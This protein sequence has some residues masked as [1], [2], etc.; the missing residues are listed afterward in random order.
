MIHSLL[1]GTRIAN[2]QRLSRAAIPGKGV[3]A[4]WI[5]PQLP[6]V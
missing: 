5:E 2:Q 4:F 6:Q 3:G 1:A